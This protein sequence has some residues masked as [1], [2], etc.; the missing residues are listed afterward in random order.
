MMPRAWTAGLMV[1]ALA[2][3]AGCGSRP[4]LSP[5]PTPRIASTVLAP[6]KTLKPTLT[7]TGSPTPPPTLSPTPRPTNTATPTSTPVP[8]PIRAVRLDFGDF[9]AH[10][11][12][13]VTLEQKLMNA[14]VNLVALGAGRLD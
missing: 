10:A 13:V 4:T 1:A 8:P 11:T 12:Q 9:T 5:T 7:P 3:L 6:T 2:L 14:N